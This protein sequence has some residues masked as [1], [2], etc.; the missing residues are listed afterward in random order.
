MFLVL[1]IKPLT[2]IKDVIEILPQGQ[3]I[4]NLIINFICA[5]VYFRQD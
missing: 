2:Q 1:K 4:V 5:D 3:N